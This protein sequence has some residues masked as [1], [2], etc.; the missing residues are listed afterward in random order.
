MGDPFDIRQFTWPLKR[1]GNL[2]S[3]LK[4]RAGNREIE[5]TVSPTGRSVQVYVDGHRIPMT[6]QEEK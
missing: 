3:T 6:D 5:V 1:G 2:Y 4:V